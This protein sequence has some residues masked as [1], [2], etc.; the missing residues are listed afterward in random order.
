MTRPLILHPDR[1]FPSDPGGQRVFDGDG[2]G[3]KSG[4]KI[5]IDC[6]C[7]LR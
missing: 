7:A 4:S 1:L 3:G 2:S 5:V 6:R